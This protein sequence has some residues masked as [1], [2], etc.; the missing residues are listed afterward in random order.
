MDY[1][2]LLGIFGFALLANIIIQI[3]Y[4]KFT[5]QDLIKKINKQVKELQKASKNT[6]DLKKLNN[7]Q[8]EIM[9]LSMKKMKQTT[10]P[11]M[12]SMLTFIV[13][14]P[15]MKNYFMGFILVQLPWT[16]P[17]IGNDVGWFLT[18]IIFSTVLNPLIKKIVG[19]EL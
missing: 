3:I 8:S 12:V 6:K 17:V 7:I 5:D 18:Y 9:N 1:T 16:L 11:M 14:F 13:L 15:V 2:T 19:T 4:K 10:K